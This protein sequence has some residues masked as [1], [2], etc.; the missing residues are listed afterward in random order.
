MSGVATQAAEACPLCHSRA[1]VPYRKDGARTHVSCMDCGCNA[2]L[3]AWNTRHRTEATEELV[4]ALTETAR[5]M[6]EAAH[7]LR[8]FGA[9]L[10]ADILCAQA[11]KSEAA[12]AR[13]T[14]A[15]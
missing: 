11:A 13:A 6:R 5:D 12:I 2:P 9:V 3:S 10:S 8:E 1:T 4:R 14:G 7:K 15:A